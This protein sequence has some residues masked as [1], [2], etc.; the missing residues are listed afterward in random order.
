ME[1]GNDLAISEIELIFHH[2]SDFI[3]QIHVVDRHHFEIEAVNEAYL[4]SYNTSK[5]DLSGKR[6]EELL[7]GD[8]GLQAIRR[9]QEAIYSK[10]PIQFEEEYYLPKQGYRMFDITL[11]PIV[12]DGSVSKLIGTARDVTQKRLNEEQIV[13]SEK[14]S[15]V[16]QLAAG[17][18]HELRNPLTSLKGFLKLIDYKNTNKEVER[19]IQVMDSEF[20]RIEQIV[21]EFLILAKPTKS[22]FTYERIDQLLDEVIEL[23]CGE[24]NMES[25]ILKKEY[26]SLR[27]HVY[28]ESN[29]LKQV[30]INLMKN[31]ME[32]IPK[33]NVNGEITVEGQ[34]FEDKLIVHIIDNGAGISETELKNLG[35]PFFT[36]KKNGTGLG[37]A[38]C[39][40][41][42]DQHSGQIDIKSKPKEG[43]RVSITLPKTPS[44]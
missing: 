32:A 28:G 2:L 15:V 39:K 17:I 6:V 21:D 36:T 44:H 29:Q 37:L 20:H 7:G 26:F 40:R 10:Q 8:Q 42:I 34:E 35:S 27:S 16:G 30:F 14:L 19:Y 4:S 25:I 9:C 41:I 3:F 38:I 18:A 22:H 33:E 31:A 12:V 43:T 1:N 24:A 23:L 5:E 13:Q 11:V